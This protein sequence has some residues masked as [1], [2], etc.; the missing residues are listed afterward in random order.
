MQFDLDDTFN[1]LDRNAAPLVSQVRPDLGYLITFDEMLDESNSSM[2]FPA[3]AQQRA[4]NFATRALDSVKA[5]LKLA[6]C[7]FSYSSPT[8]PNHINLM[9][10]KTQHRIAAVYNACPET[11]R[12]GQLLRQPRKIGGIFFIDKAGCDRVRFKVNDSLFDMAV[13]GVLLYEV[14]HS[15]LVPELKECIWSTFEDVVLLHDHL[16]LYFNDDYKHAGTP[17]PPAKTV[18]AIVNI[19]LVMIGH[20]KNAVIGRDTLIDFLVTGCYSWIELTKDLLYKSICYLH[21]DQSDEEPL[22][23]DLVNEEHYTDKISVRSISISG[24]NEDYLKDKAVNQSR[25]SQFEV[26]VH[27]CA[28]MEDLSVDSALV[29]T[30]IPLNWEVLA[31]MNNKMPIILMDSHSPKHGRN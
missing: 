26:S 3:Q 17:F 14:C 5:S 8:I 29:K 27:N 31:K 4:V 10:L 24:N 18:Q 16:N 7:Q 22:L 28:F 9:T 30:I 11:M 25:P 15:D 20:S 21:F 1:S 13:P 6:E 2:E 19:Q 12:L 23:I